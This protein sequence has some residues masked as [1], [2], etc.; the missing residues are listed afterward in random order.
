MNSNNLDSRPSSFFYSY[1]MKILYWGPAEVGKTTSFMS[2]R[3]YYKENAVDSVIKVQTST[4]RTLWNEY[5]ALKFTLPGYNKSLDV[6]VHVSTVTGQERFISTREFA[7]SS[8]DGVIF[9]ADCRKKFIRETIHSYEELV[10]FMPDDVPIVVQA[11]FQ[12]LKKIISIDD[13]ED[14]LSHVDCRYREIVPTVAS[15]GI[16]TIKAFNLLLYYVLFK[17]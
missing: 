5:S 12:D 7:A 4:G 8:A 13:L 11:N 15:K 10:T 16:N 1:Q 2:V 17:K 3:E 9:V 14:H 6:I